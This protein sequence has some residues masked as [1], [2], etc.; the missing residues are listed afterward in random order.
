MFSYLCVYNYNKLSLELHSDKDACTFASY[1]TVSVSIRTRDKNEIWYARSVMT[2]EN[3]SLLNLFRI[4]LYWLRDTS[5]PQST[6]SGLKFNQAIF[7]IYELAVKLTDWMLWFC[8]P[9]TWLG[10]FAFSLSGLHN[11]NAPLVPTKEFCSSSKHALLCMIC[12][13]KLKRSAHIFRKIS[14]LYGLYMSQ[15]L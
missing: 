4:M 12:M 7:H 14:L 6:V 10:D 11:R 1:Q 5:A 3:V 9:V 15:L 8:C 2:L 13:A